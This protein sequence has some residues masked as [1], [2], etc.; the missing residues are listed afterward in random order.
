M[1]DVNGGTR[2]CG[3]TLQDINGRAAVACGAASTTENAA[4]SA[5]ISVS[6]MRGDT[7]SLSQR[8]PRG[9]PAQGGGSFGWHGG[10][11]AAAQGGAKPAASG[12]VS[13]QALRR[14]CMRGRREKGGEARV[15]GI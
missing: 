4:T 11:S 7:R 14:A 15:D 12:D 1:L 6:P 13:V 3:R 2:R 5:S 9:E 10:R 8:M